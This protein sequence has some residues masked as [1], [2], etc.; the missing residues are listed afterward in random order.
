MNEMMFAVAHRF[1]VAICEL[2]LVR[3]ASLQPQRVGRPRKTEPRQQ[4][5]TEP[6]TPRKKK[7]KKI[8]SS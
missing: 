1:A 6:V 3:S 7:K 5:E 2:R 4:Y 8:I